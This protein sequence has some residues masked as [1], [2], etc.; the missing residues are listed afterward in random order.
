MARQLRTEYVGAIYHVMNRGDRGEPIFR[1]DEDRRRFGRALGETCARAPWQV[2]AFGLMSNHFH[3]VIETPQPTLVAGLKWW[4]GADTQRFNRRHQVRG[5]LFVGRYKSLL[6]DGSSVFYLRVG[7]DYVHLNPQRARL[8]PDGAPLEAYPW[9]SS[10][11]ISQRP[12]GGRCGR[13]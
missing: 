10:R 3:A 8:L 4:L 5:H 6:V 9:S 12:G 2:H 7:C 11:I 1:D 13:P